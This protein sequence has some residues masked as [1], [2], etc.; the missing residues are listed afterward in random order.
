MTAPE[1]LPIAYEVIPN[2]VRKLFAGL[3]IVALIACSAFAAFAVRAGFDQGSLDERCTIL[4]GLEL[5]WD[6]YWPSVC[7]DAAVNRIKI[8]FWSAAAS[9]AFVLFLLATSISITRDPYRARPKPPP[10]HSNE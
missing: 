6:D 7:G 2:P 5:K 9:A 3:A 4:G 1:P 8:V 10:Q